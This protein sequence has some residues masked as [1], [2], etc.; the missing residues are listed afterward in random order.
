MDEVEMTDR[1]CAFQCGNHITE[2][3]PTTE[4]VILNA[5][6]GRKTV[7]GFICNSCNS[8]TGSL[9]DA[10]LA[11]QLNP[12]GLLLGIRRQRGVV[13]SQIFS[14]SNGGNIQLLSDGT[15]T[16]AKPSCDI[17]ADGNNTQIRI[18]AR[19]TRE[20]R[21]LIKGVRRKN[22]ALRA[23]CLNDLVSNAEAVQNFSSEWTGFNLEFG[24]VRA[25][26]S[27]VKSTVALV[28]D[29]GV[30]PNRC[31]LALDYLL[32][33]DAEPCFGYFYEKDHDLVINRPAER[34]F[35]CVYVN[36]VSDTGAILGYIELYSLYR[37]VLCLSTSYSG[38]NFTNVY[39]IDP[40]KG[41]ELDLGIHL[42]LAI[43]DIR[44]AYNYEKYDEGVLRTAVNNLAECIADTD[45]D[46]ALDR[47]I[48][49]AVENAF[50][51]CDAGQGE[52]LTDGQVHQV[53]DAA[54]AD[55]EPFI[56][57][58]LVRLNYTLNSGT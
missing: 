41:E 45:F 52:H 23:R 44:S 21:R 24:G 12:L 11:R 5:L 28:Y 43:S 25:G 33:E 54:L 53:V 40:V 39:A 46:R 8:R 3:T 17:T 14:T 10:E 27:L 49:E 55:L 30:D 42:D 38:R 48:R 57:H 35:H 4:H 20:L 26:R 9:W 51:K 47:N 13:P 50:A 37:L 31:D 32:H 1:I 7:V 18:R 2:D 22:P 6:G 36:G 29:A 19:T 16:I 58:N 15:R 56:K 34:P